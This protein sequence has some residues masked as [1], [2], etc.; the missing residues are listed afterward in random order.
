VF[1][2]FIHSLLSI[3]GIVLSD[4]VKK[5]LL[6]FKKFVFVRIEALFTPIFSLFGSR[7]LLTYDPSKK[8]DGTGAQLQRIFAIFA[9]AKRYKLGFKYTKLV[10]VA[11]HPLDEIGSSKELEAYLSQ[12]N[13]LFMLPE[14]EFQTIKNMD[15]YCDNLRF[16]N[17]L[18]AVAK[19]YLLHRRITLHIVAP[20]G[21]SDY[22]PDSYSEISGNLLHWDNA[23]DLYKIHPKKRISI[24][25]RSGVG[26]MAIQKGEKFSREIHV[27]YFL[28]I[29][30]NIIL[31]LSNEDDFEIFVFTDAPTNDLQYEP[32]LEQTELWSTSPGFNAGIMNVKGNDLSTIVK[33]YGE[34]CTIH[35]GGNPISAISLMSKSDYLI[36]GRSSLS[37]VASILNLNGTIYY[38]PN[39]WHPPMSH[40]KI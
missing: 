31:S 40:W 35:I 14:S 18:V 21:V 3:I 9:L 36:M 5:I 12:L 20:Y 8:I 34:K 29:I 15:I 17:L 11:V 25:Y 26:G 23:S 16:I 19:S 1:N 22:H 28:N 37:Y 10:S 6:I 4:K 30:D 2:R 24:H 13:F 27:D 7:L 32:P 33:K 39:F 38:P